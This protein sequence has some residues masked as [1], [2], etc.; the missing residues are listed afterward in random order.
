MSGVVLKAAS[1]EPDFRGAEVCPS[2]NFGERR[3]GHT[4][5]ALILHYT[6]METGESAQDW[7]CAPQSEVSSHYLVH[8]D[9]R[10]VQMVRESDRAWHAGRGTW[11]GRDDVNSWSIGVEIANAGHPKGLP[12][13]PEVQVQAVLKLGRDICRRHDIPP[14]RVLAH[15]DIAP[16]RKVDPGERFPWQRLAEA[17][18]GHFVA[19][20]A[21][22]GGHV[23]GPE[24]EGPA[25]EA[26][27]R[28]LSRYGYNI[29]ISGVYDAN[30][31]IVVREFQRHFR[32]LEVNGLADATTCIILRELLYN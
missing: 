13:F 28:L 5:D 23:L 14:K 31:Q 21:V 1:F 19:M 16:G 12:E 20:A 3:D 32:P 22:S 26:L 11:Q 9:G 7:L 15:S 18:L 6:G 8:E 30:T 17:G 10:I 25:V 29:D 24:D 2:P 4:P 27:Q